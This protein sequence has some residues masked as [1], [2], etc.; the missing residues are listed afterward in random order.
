VVQTSRLLHGLKW[1]KSLAAGRLD[2]CI[3]AQFSHH[4]ASNQY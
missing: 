2:Y 3:T 4:T 1:S